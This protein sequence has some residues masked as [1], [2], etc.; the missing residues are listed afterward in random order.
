MRPREEVVTEEQLELRRSLSRE[1]QTAL[2][3][4][5]WAVARAALERLTAAAPSSAE[6]HQRLGRVL[7]AQ[8]ELGRAEACYL[9]AL[10]LDADYAAALVG[11]GRVESRMGRLQA[12]L[13]HLDEAIELEPRRAEAH[14]A[15]G[16]ALGGLGR[17]DEALAA[18]FRSLQFEPTSN[19]C[20]LRI[21]ELHLERNR[22]DQAL[23]RLN[24]VLD[25]A[26]DDAEARLL[27]GRAYVALGQP[28]A[29]VDD[30]RQAAS[31]LPDRPDAFY[32]LA[33]A[34]AATEPP[35]YESALEAARRAEE[36]APAWSAARELTERLRR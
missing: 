30:L 5:D 3:Q 36:L 11:L 9:R 33:V 19:P 28:G 6:A 4:G 31:A 35:P 25:I 29:A 7:E 12:G 18:Y 34:L 8:G 15:R 20:L 13:A 2:D 16:E 32:H 24:Q 1:A 22:A 27:R 17:K 23:A 21:A 14:L 10:E 26:A